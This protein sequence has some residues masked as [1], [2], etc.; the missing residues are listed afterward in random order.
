MKKD[1]ATIGVSDMMCAHC[2]ASVEK[3]LAAV[4]VKAKAD[5]LKKEVAV[6]YDGAKISIDEIR[7]A[8]QEAG[9]TVV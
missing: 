2:E 1:K 4:G 9:Y 8:I 3:A 5:H 6:Q 7:S